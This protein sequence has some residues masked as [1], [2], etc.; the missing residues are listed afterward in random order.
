MTGVLGNIELTGPIDD[1]R[2]HYARA[3]LLLAPYDDLSRPRV[4]TEAQVSGIPALAYDDRGSRRRWDPAGILVPREAPGRH[5]CAGSPPSGTTT[6][7]YAGYSAAALREAEQARSRDSKRHRGRVEASLQRRS[8]DSLEGASATAPARR[9]HRSVSVILPVRQGAATI[10]EQLEALSL[11]TYRASGSSSSA[12][13]ASTDGT[14][15]RVLAWRGLCPLRIVDASGRRG[16]AHA[17]NVGIDEA[18]GDYIVICDADDVVD[19]EWME[20]MV[21][22]LH[23]HEIVTGRHDQRMLNT[24]DLYEWMGEDD[25]TD[26]EVDYGHL[27]YASGATWGSGARSP[28]SWPDSMRACAA[29]ED[30]DWS[31]RAHYAGYDVYFEPRAVIHCR[32]SSEVGAVAYKWFRSGMTEPLLYRRHRD[33]GQPAASPREALETWR[34]LWRNAPAAW[35]DPTLANRWLA[36]AA[37]RSGRVVGSVRHRSMFL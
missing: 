36:N 12:T 10:A 11:Q 15:A 19:P 9:R 8:P 6:T 20:R 25:Q 16:V 32:R 30:I 28:K 33:R 4:V 22:A 23:E 18:K 13:T 24:P 3:R 1:P 31:W 7:A 35:R 14:R 27:R 34:W 5:G 26:A 29:G 2:E 17:R 37:L 21:E